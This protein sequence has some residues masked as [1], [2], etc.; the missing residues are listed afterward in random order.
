MFVQLLCSILLFNFHSIPIYVSPQVP[1][2]VGSPTR[3]ILKLRS[4]LSSRW[5]HSIGDHTLH[6]WPHSTGDFTFLFVLDFSWWHSRGDF[7]QVAQFWWCCSPF[8]VLPTVVI[9][10]LKVFYIL[11][12]ALLLGLPSSLYHHRF[13]QASQDS[14]TWSI[15]RAKKLPLRPF[16]QFA[17][18]K[19]LCRLW[20][21][22]QRGGQTAVEDQVVDLKGFENIWRIGS[23]YSFMK[24]Y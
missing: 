12:N 1:L 17:I 20:Q 6:S 22:F 16:C 14:E 21:R 19:T 3:T 13:I 10:K 4:F 11:Q 24:N 5:P 18:D 15:K 9:D 7:G 8:L 2:Q 23:E